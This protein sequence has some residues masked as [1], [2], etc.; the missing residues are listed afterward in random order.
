MKIKVLF[1]TLLCIVHMHGMEN[2]VSEVKQF[3]ESPEAQQI[4]HT[5]INVV[6]SPEGKQVIGEAK[7]FVVE[8]IGNLVS[9]A[10][11]QNN[12]AGRSEPVSRYQVPNLQLDSSLSPK[13]YPSTQIQKKPIKKVTDLSKNVNQIAQT[14]RTPVPTSRAYTPMGSTYSQDAVIN[15]TVPNRSLSPSVSSSQ[16][17]NMIMGRTYSEGDIWDILAKTNQVLY[18]FAVEHKLSLEEALMFG[19][20]KSKLDIS[21]DAVVDFIKTKLPDDKKVADWN[22]SEKYKKLQKN[23]PQKYKEII[24]EVMKSVMDEDS[25]QKAS[26]PLADTHIELAEQHIV[27][28]DGTIKKQWVGLIATVITGIGM[29]VWALYGQITGHT[30]AP[31]MAP[32]NMP[33]FSPTM[34]PTPAPT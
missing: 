22:Q 29:G 12:N 16:D 10:G 32:T 31:T 18:N 9:G 5:V 1:C 4:E 2:F 15:M 11:S 6:T 34:F 25:G 20:L 14:A 8:K 24:F 28:Q 13:R 17:N 26:S 19:E 33:T 21:P 7:D 3:A 30:A 27:G 23:D